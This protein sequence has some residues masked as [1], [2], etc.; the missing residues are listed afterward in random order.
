[1]LMLII[2]DAG[3]GGGR[4]GDTGQEETGEQEHVMRKMTG[5]LIKEW[6]QFV[7][8]ELAARKEVEKQLAMLL[9]EMEFLREEV[10]WCTFLARRNL[11]GFCRSSYRPATKSP[12]G[13]P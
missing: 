5:V 12:S 4:G 13:G 10:R 9:Q 11:T 2:T 1:M 7:M 3:R 8:K 6:S